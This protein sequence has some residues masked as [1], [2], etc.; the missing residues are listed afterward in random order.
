MSATTMP[1]RDI[2]TQDDSGSQLHH[3]I[4]F[5]IRNS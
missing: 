2:S 3:S 5:L 4:N 1:G